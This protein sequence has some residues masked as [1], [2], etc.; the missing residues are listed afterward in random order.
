M[1]DYLN[2]QEAVQIREPAS[3]GSLLY[4]SRS[5]IAPEEAEAVV[6]GIVATSVTRNAAVGLTGALLFTGT[7]FAQALEGDKAAIEDLMHRVTCDIRHDEI[8]IVEQGP[9]EQRRF[10]TWSMAY[11]GPSQ[12]VS[13][14]VTRLLNDPSPAERRRAADWLGELLCEFTARRPFPTLIEQPSIP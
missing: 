6:A 5:T 4:I 10:D 14:H 13:R 8:V 2:Q 12:F 9:L 3:L 1:A 11:F 7:H